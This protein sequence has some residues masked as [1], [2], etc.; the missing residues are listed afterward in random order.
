MKAKKSNAM[1]GVVL[2]LILGFAYFLN[3]TDFLSKPLFPTAPKQAE[4]AAGPTATQ[5]SEMMKQQIAKNRSP[6]NPEEEGGPQRPSQPEG[7]PSEPA[8][9]KPK[10][11]RNQPVP[12]ET[13][14]SAHWDAKDSYVEKASE[15]LKKKRGY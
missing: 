5:S 6:Q 4:G 8:I 2:F 10:R 12:N 1:W 13:S 11:Q 3:A 14:T 15:D 7:V 9:F